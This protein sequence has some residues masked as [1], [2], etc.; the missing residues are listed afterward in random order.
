VAIKKLLFLYILPAMI[1]A[2]VIGDFVGLQFHNQP[3][4][5]DEASPVP[6]GWYA[7]NLNIPDA[8]PQI[9][10]NV[11]L[12]KIKDLLPPKDND[13]PRTNDDIDITITTITSTPEQYIAKEDLSGPDAQ[14]LGIQGT[15]GQFFS[16]KTFSVGTLLE[17]PENVFIFFNGNKVE[18]FD[19]NNSADAIDFWKVV[20]YYAQHPT[21]YGQ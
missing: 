8:D 3:A 9:L 20:T 11:V 5:T 2:G 17:G 15:W 16:Y 4:P 14:M 6:P 18:S 10:D 19:Y 1:L 13:A 21:Y 12:T 7:H